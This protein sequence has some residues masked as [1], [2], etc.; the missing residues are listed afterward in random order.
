MSN[1]QN[2]QN[3]ANT[4]QYDFGNV[5]PS[6]AVG[7][8]PQ[9]R[10]GGRPLNTAMKGP[11]GG[12]RPMTSIKAVFNATSKGEGFSKQ[13]KVDLSKIK[14]TGPQEQFKVLE[15]EINTLIEESANL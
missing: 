8:V 15:K 9:S 13:G 4:S 12:N 2:F 3:Q 11:E 1:N 7:G 5:K 10:A 6:Q 14:E